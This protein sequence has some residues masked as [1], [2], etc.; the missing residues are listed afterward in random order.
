M[1]ELRTSERGGVRGCE[2][3]FHSESTAEGKLQILYFGNDW[4]CMYVFLQEPNLI[5]KL[6]Q[7]PNLC[8][9]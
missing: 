4:E 5:G 2:T 6:S 8:N 9:N 3:M 1:L 7:F